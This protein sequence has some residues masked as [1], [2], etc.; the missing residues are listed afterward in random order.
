MAQGG[1]CAAPMRTAIY[2]LPQH[3]CVPLL[4]VHVRRSH[5][6]TKQCAGVTMV[7]VRDDL[8]DSARSTCPTMLEYKTMAETDSMYNTPPCWSIYVCGLAFQKLLDDGGLEAMQERNVAKV[9]RV[10]LSAALPGCCVTC[11]SLATLPCLFV[12]GCTTPILGQHSSFHRCQWSL[13]ISQSIVFTQCPSL[14]IST[15]RG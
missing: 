1:P 8:L 6:L 10:L 11:G 14:V 2:R 9:C 15:S 4:P 12:A 3:F 7:I 13:F 5:Q